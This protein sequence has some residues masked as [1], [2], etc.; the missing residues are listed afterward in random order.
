MTSEILRMRLAE[1]RTEITS[2]EKELESVKKVER[3][4]VRRDWMFGIYPVKDRSYLSEIL[5]PAVKMYRLSGVILNKEQLE[6]AGWSESETRDGG[7]NY[8][9]NTATG[10]I[11]KA[12]GGGNI[13][14]RGGGWGGTTEEKVIAGLV[15]DELNAFLVEHPEGGDVTKTITSQPGFR[16]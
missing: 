7:M 14:I 11:I 2:I 4:K 8:L 5:D 12:D 3:A 13:Y 9:F 10:K 16:W 1:L 6:T 15:Y